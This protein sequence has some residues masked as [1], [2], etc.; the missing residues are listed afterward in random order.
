MTN[1]EIF[2]D[3]IHDYNLVVD[4]NTFKLHYSNASHWHHKGELILE[5]EN[6]GNGYKLLV[7]LE[8][9]HRINYSE[10]EELYIL[11]S[12]AKESKIEIVEVKR[13]L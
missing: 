8:K 12:A 13:E 10:A 4:E 6:D 3:G 5:L 11:L 9:K 7:P 2:V 1:K